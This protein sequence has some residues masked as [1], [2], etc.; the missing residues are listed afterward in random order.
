MTSEPVTLGTSCH[1][2][3][4]ETPDRRVLACT[5]SALREVR[6]AGPACRRSRARKGRRAAP[7]P[8]E[9]F[10]HGVQRTR[11]ATLEALRATSTHHGEPTP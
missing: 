9:A 4:P 1:A 2:N 7:P 5:K 8:Y 10:L 6:E 11:E 3:D